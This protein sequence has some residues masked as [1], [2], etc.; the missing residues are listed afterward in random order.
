MLDSSRRY[1]LN[2][3]EMMPLAATQMD[4]QVIMLSEVSQRRTNI[5]CYCLYV[6]SE[7]KKIQMHLCR[8]QT[9]TYKH[10]KQMDG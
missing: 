10:I 8:K 6:E 5:I 2:Q 1:V 9:Q 4:I 7:K 3:S